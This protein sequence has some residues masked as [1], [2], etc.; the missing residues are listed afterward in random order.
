[1]LLFKEKRK[2][3]I[4]FN[5]KENAQFQKYFMSTYFFYQIM[6][7]RKKELRDLTFREVYFR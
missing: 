2:R 7:Q 6:D 1:M 3:K 5:W 4:I